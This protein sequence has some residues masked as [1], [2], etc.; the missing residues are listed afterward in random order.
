MAL[1]VVVGPTA[2]GKTA[3]AVSLAE[4]LDGEIVSVDSVQIYRRFDLGSGKPTDAERARAPHHC[5]DLVDPLDSMDAARFSELADLAI[6]EISARGRRPI[7]CGGTFLW[8]RALLFGL[9]PAPPADAGVRE[10]HAAV[11]AQE[12]REALHRRLATVDPIAARRLAPNDFVRVSRALEV[13]ELSGVTLSAWQSAHGFRAPRYPARLVGIRHSGEAL[14]HRIGDRVAAM[15][16][17]GWIDEVRDLIADGYAEARPMRSVGYRQI[18][19][20]I[21]G[22]QSTGD[23]DLATRIY[24]ATR[25]FARRQRTWLRDQPVRWLSP[26]EAAA[27]PATVLAELDAPLD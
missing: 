7:V 19:E 6:A 23:A 4:R 11:A 26:V 1:T 3:L 20:E 27:L 9:A 13:Y 24:R 2:S 14:D 25:V 8:V 5:I 10:R 12:G 18:A 21:L 16:A 22:N 17:A 15:L